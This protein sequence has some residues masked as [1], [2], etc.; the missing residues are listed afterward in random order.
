MKLRFNTFNDVVLRYA[1]SDAD[2]KIIRMLDFKNEEEPIDYGQ[3]LRR[4]SVFAGMLRE[5]GLKPKDRVVIMLPTSS[6]FVY[7]FFGTLLAGGIPV[8]TYPPSTFG[9]NSVFLSNLRHIFQSSQARF[10]GS[11]PRI[12]GSFRETFENFPFLEHVFNA[13]EIDFNSGNPGEMKPAEV[14]SDD[15]SLLQYTSGSTGFPKGVVL[16]HGNLLN[17]VHAI[18]EAIKI[19][20][21][22][23]FGVSWLPLFHDMG[24]IGCLLTAL[25]TAT[26]VALMPTESFMMRPD[27]WLHNISKYKATISPSPNFG[28]Y[29]CTRLLNTTRLKGVDLSSW[30]VALTGA[31]AIDINVLERF[32]TLLK[33]YGFSRR[34]FLPAYGLAES[35]LAVTIAPLED[36]LKVARLNRGKLENDGTAEDYDEEDATLTKIV[37]VG[38]PVKGQQAEIHDSEG[39]RSPDNRVGEIWIKG[40]SVTS[41]YFNNPGVTKKSF[42]QDWFKTGDLGFK[43]NGDLYITGRI[44]E[45]IIKR[46]RNY[47]PYDI[48]KALWNIAGIREGRCA[49]FASWNH[50]ESS[51]DLVLVIETAKTS[52]EADLDDLA[53]SVNAVVLENIGLKP[54]RIVFIPPKS[55][56]KTSSGKIQ[57][58]LCKKLLEEGKLEVFGERR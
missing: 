8:P 27:R 12:L 2:L 9:N 23:D 45:L 28:Y 43:R 4:S 56:P 50:A 26:P 6:A 22:T 34:A 37:S 14:R 49:A 11:E 40:L 53:K 41:G 52:S 19:N 38:K 46:G 51:E 42:R 57:R 35:S 1:E 33:P 18:S 17:N 16:T 30:R 5:K 24:L 44:K 20:R 13:S 21:A 31:E 25:Y 10:F 58:L 36:N 29:L 32:E 15:V 48:E 47:Y 39:N 54:D 7:L 55:I 3:V